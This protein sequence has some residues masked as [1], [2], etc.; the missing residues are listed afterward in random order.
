MLAVFES[1]LPIFL[2]ILAGVALKRSPL[3]DQ[4]GWPGMEQLTYWFL[5]P[6]LLF[7]TVLN[8]DFTGLELDRMLA[9]LLIALGAMIAL[10]LAMWWPVRSL[11]VASAREFGSMFQSSIRWNGFMA[12]AIA[13]SLYGSAGA[14]V[15]ALVMAVIIVPINVA[16][17]S[18]LSYFSGRDMALGKVLRQI[19]I[20]PFIIAIILAMILR[21][22]S[23]GL[24]GP[25]DETLTLV[26]SAALGLGLVTIGAG[27]RLGDLFTLR[28][29]LWLPVVIKLL[30]FPA[31]FV[32]IALAFEVTG[33]E[34]L[35]L[36]LCAAVPTAMNGYLL[37][38]QL[39]SDA[40][41]YAAITTIQTALSF[42]T[43]PAVLAV[44]A[45]FV[46]G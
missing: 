17:V 14:A 5:Y 6:A 1:S 2:L 18:V 46:S 32:A 37:A 29:T 39:G 44:T 4:A 20:N 15:V 26:G 42:F 12:L 40:E 22:V 11:G 43:I 21:V 33:E 34:L 3:V 10:S 38:R 9:A 19:A 28:A 8:A 30:V 45:Q 31:V 13:Q 7:V 24:Y 41:L 23:G 35:Y 27:L 36:T 25:L 16:S